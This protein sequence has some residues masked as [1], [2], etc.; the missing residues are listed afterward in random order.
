ML[1]ACCRFLCPSVGPLRVNK[2]VFELGLSTCFDLCGWSFLSDPF[3]WGGSCMGVCFPSLCVARH[4]FW[5]VRCQ[6]FVPYPYAAVLFCLFCPMLVLSH[7]SAWRLR[8]SPLLHPVGEKSALSR[9]LSRGSRS[10]G[11]LWL[12]LF[13]LCFLCIPTCGRGSLRMS[14]WNPFSFPAKFR[15]AGLSSIIWGVAPPLVWPRRMLAVHPFLRVE[16]LVGP[17]Y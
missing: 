9:R 10:K 7:P 5:G 6:F 2:F 12:I 14:M 13:S 17:Y 16:K 3:Y 1:T 8:S 15:V 4:V 11:L